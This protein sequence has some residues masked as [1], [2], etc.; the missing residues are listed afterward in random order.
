MELTQN[1]QRLDELRR[2]ASDLQNVVSSLAQDRDRLT[3]EKATLDREKVESEAAKSAAEA[4]WQR[5]DTEAKQVEQELYSL[6]NATRK[7]RAR[8]DRIV[9]GYCHKRGP[10]T[11]FDREMAAATETEF[12]ITIGVVETGSGA[13]RTGD[14]SQRA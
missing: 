7:K 3:V 6:E 2:E 8:L 4:A 12:R 13:P 5:A 10:A 11:K 14:S 1:D 9:A